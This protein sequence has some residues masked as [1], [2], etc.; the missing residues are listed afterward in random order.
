MIGLFKTLIENEGRKDMNQPFFQNG[1]VLR[2]GQEGD[3][4]VSMDGIE[5][6]CKGQK[7]RTLLWE[8][9]EPVERPG[10]FRTIDKKYVRLW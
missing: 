1:V 10:G 6:V 8:S 7:G 3:R 9:V 2:K 4:A 5:Y